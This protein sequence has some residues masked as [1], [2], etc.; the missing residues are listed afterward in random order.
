MIEHFREIQKTDPLYYYSTDVY[1]VDSQEEEIKLNLMYGRD[2]EL[3]ID[4]EMIEKLKQGKILLFT[5]DE[6]YSR[7]TYKPKKRPTINENNNRG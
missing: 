7:I 6:Y 4:D 2:G 3:E 5:G 1:F